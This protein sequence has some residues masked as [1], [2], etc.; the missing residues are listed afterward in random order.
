MPLRVCAQCGSS[1]S[2]FPACAECRVVHYCS[3]EC[4]KG[5][6]KPHKPRCARLAAARAA[7]GGGLHCVAAINGRPQLQRL[8][9]EQR[10]MLQN[11]VLECRKD[12]FCDIPVTVWVLRGRDQV[13]ALNREIH[14]YELCVVEGCMSIWGPGGLIRFTPNGLAN[15]RMY[16]IECATTQ[17]KKGL[18][19][20]KLKKAAM[21]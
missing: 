10:E 11:L 6:W 20:S 5:H 15:A 3:R 19:R 2:G 16:V 7:R 14:K 21:V 18:K 12:V 4:Q 8:V 9:G 1:G 13:K 17:S